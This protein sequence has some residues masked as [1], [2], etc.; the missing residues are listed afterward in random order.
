MRVWSWHHP[1]GILFTLR[2]LRML[3]H[4]NSDGQVCIS[5]STHIYDKLLGQKQEFAACRFSAA[6]VS[7]R[8]NKSNWCIHII[9]I[10]DD[11]T[12]TSWSGILRLVRFRE[13]HIQRIWPGRI[14]HMQ[15]MFGSFGKRTQKKLKH[16]ASWMVALRRGFE[17]TTE[18]Q[19]GK[20]FNSHG[21]SNSIQLRW[22]SILHTCVLPRGTFETACATKGLGF[23]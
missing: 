12:I 15:P 9:Q 20:C 7:Q 21:W 23:T 19:L 5:G 22:S 11:E 1:I 17:K 13:G 3:V 6:T 2:I 18:L 16:T 4:M 14:L 10:S 8:M